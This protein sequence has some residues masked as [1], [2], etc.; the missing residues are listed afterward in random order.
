MVRVQSVEGRVDFT[1]TFTIAPEALRVESTLR[2]T[3]QDN[4]AE[5]VESLPVFLRDGV[6][7]PMNVSTVIEFQQGNA[8]VHATTDWH[9]GVSS[10]R[11]TRNSAAVLI[12]FDRPRRVKTA[13]EWWDAYLSRVSCRNV[14]VDL[15]AIPDTPQVVRETSVSYRIRSEKK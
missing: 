9:D 15:L 3:A 8:W 13:D 14:L 4:F 5:L 6:A 2:T 11:L 1:R 12:E 10:V 7:G